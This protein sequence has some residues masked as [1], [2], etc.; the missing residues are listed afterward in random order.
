MIFQLDSNFSMRLLDLLLEI[1]QFNDRHNRNLLIRGFPKGPIQTISRSDLSEWQSGQ[2][3]VN[4]W[5]KLIHENII[6]YHLYGTTT[7]CLNIFSCYYLLKLNLFG[8]D[9]FLD[10]AA[11]K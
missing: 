6:I 7:I 11:R 1:E 4:P 3:M 8:I 9:T 2:F 5:L 10:A